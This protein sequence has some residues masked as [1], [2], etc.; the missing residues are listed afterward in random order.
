MGVS[1]NA[2]IRVEHLTAAYEGDVIIDNVSF[3]VN[4]GEVFVMLGSSGCGKTTLLKH[5]N[6]LY[7]PA[8]GRVLIDGDDI[9]TAQ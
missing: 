5:M 9:A 8:S 4:R 7:S 6:G 1:E 2:I 3:E